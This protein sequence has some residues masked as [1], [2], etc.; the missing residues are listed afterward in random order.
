[1]NRECAGEGAVS[2]V[3]EAGWMV[4]GDGTDRTSQTWFHTGLIIVG[5]FG[6]KFLTRWNAQPIPQGLFVGLGLWWVLASAACSFG[7]SEHP[8]HRVVRVMTFNILQGGGD[9]SNVGFPDEDFGGSRVDELATVIIR[10]GVDIV[11]VQEDCRDERLLKALGPAW[12]RQGNVY[13][14]YPLSESTVRPYLTFVTISLDA[15]CRLSLV[16]GHWF[17]PPK[18][19]GPDIAQLELKRNPQIAPED[20]ARRV[21]VGCNNPAGPRGYDETLSFLQRAQRL[22]W[23]LILTGDFNEPSHLDWTSRYASSGADRWVNN[24]TS[25]PLRFSIDW[26]GSR[27]LERIG[28]VDSFRQVHP[29]EVA[30]PGNTWTPPYPPQT[31]GRRPYGDQC[32]DR[33]DRIYHFGAK[34]TAI[35]A[36]VVGEQGVATAPKSFLRW[37]SDHRAVVVE[38]R[39][40]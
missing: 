24:P 3:E 36:N 31:P 38:Y 39:I 1:L 26:P 4:G 37:P 33:I 23:P 10:S 17:P 40:D 15:D 21:I 32:L 2:L 19:Y 28:M 13:S 9:A 25:T 16:N 8:K 30:R 29:D 18:G 5:W 12:S 20:L 14:K 7:Q 22:G 11:G 35:E 27:A 6:P 34:I